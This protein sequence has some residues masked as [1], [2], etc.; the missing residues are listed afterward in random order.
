MTAH[1]IWSLAVLLLWAATHTDASPTWHMSDVIAAVEQVELSNPGMQPAALLLA[2]RRSAALDDPFL[3]HF[4][5][6]DNATRPQADAT[7]ALSDYLAE[8]L[9]HRVREDGREEG[10]VLT[11]DGTTVALGPVLLGL[12]A[13]LLSKGRPRG[14]FQLTLARHLALAATRPAGT[15]GLF[16]DGCWDSPASPREFRLSGQP[17]SL[18]TALVHGGMDGLVLGTAVPS[19]RRRGGV[20]LSSLLRSYYSPAPEGAE[21]PGL[22]ATRRRENFRQLVGQPPLLARQVVRTLELQL[23][24][25]GRPKMERK[26]RQKVAALVNTEINEFVLKFM[27]C[28]PIVPRCM[29]RAAPYRGTPTQLSLPLDFMYIHHTSTPSAPCLTFQS[30]AANM[31]AIQRFH[32]DVRGWDDIGYSFVAGSDGY[33]YEGRGW[34]WQGAHTLG[35]NAIGYGV[36]FIGDYSARLPASGALELVRE[37]LGSCAV[38]SAML[39]GNYTVHGHRQVVSTDCPGDALYQE[40]TGW[41]HFGEVTRMKPLLETI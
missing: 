36:A 25:M 32:Q 26:E 7:A 13:G 20:S 41:E 15:Q 14:L 28:P 4:L 29:W 33:L 12:E 3:Q 37:R 18:T 2:L 17:Q 9:A 22:I 1:W 38:A 24:L 21:D 30:C 10:V 19:A 31:R 27:D 34:Q 11:A 6:P 23:R 5:G 39:V 35:H 40:I 16:P 8:A